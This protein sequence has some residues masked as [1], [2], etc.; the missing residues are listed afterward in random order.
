MAYAIFPP[1]G[2]ARIGNSA[3]DFFVGPERPDSLGVEVLPDGT[4]R[5]IE[6]TKDAQHRVKRQAA[7]FQVFEVDAAGLEPPAVL[8]DGASVRWT[9][10]L[11]NKKDAVVRPGSP[12]SQPTRPV[13]A[14]GAEDRVIDSG[15]VSVDAGG[16]A[17]L[18]GTYR[19]TSVHLGDASADASQRLLVLGGTGRA[20]SPTNAPI[21]GSFY[22]NPGWF[23]DLADGPVSAEVVL[24][25]GTVHA[26]E[27]AWVIVAPPD[28]APGCGGVVTLY[29]VLLQVGVDLGQAEVPVRPNFWRDVQPMIRRASTLQ[30]VTNDATWPLVSTDWAALADPSPAA[31]ML[32]AENAEFVRSAE[33]LLH[34]HE[35]RDWQRQCLSGV[36]SRRLRRDATG[37]GG[38]TRTAH[39]YR[40][41]RYGRA[42]LLPRHR[43]RHHRHRPADLPAAIPVPRRSRG[44]E[45]GRSHG[46]D[47]AAV[48]SRLPQV[49]Q[50][51]VADSA[52]RCRTTGSGFPTAV[53]AAGDEPRAAGPR[54]DAS[55]CDHAR[56]RRRLAS[57]SGSRPD[58]LRARGL[59][60]REVDACVV[61]AGVAGAATALR[62]ARQGMRVALMDR[63]AP[64][65]P[66]GDAAEVLPP[67]AVHALAAWGVHDVWTLG[68]TCRGVLSRWRG[69]AAGFTDYELLGCTR[70]TGR[71]ARRRRP[72]PH[73]ARSTRGRRRDRSRSCQRRAIAGSLDA[74]LR[75]TPA[76]RAHLLPSPDRRDRPLGS[77]DRGA[78]RAMPP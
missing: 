4:E 56:G 27:P 2:I 73:R 54:R 45:G 52:T 25:D 8:P 66:V 28:F 11:V 23:D 17:S 31:A 15:N 7:R 72:M 61:G 49:Q 1:I 19:D 50:R 58:T 55:R 29:D 13:L 18:D 63:P 70:S 75:T 26:A 53:V 78:S 68:A 77:S 43:G 16:A 62:L 34:Q 9:V 40:A 12:P 37:G 33:A 22:N 42:G 21:G 44:P 71:H 3:T 51:L 65:G 38:S 14:A 36:G 69:D 10:R 47:G 20:A 24:A 46:V 59:M 57:R 30:W 41:R 76:M 60:Q 32:R 74:G 39:A 64:L 67:I 5:E 48:A 6:S 35:L